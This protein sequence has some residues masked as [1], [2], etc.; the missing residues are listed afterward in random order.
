[1]NNFPLNILKRVYIVEN[2][3]AQTIKLLPSNTAFTLAEVLITLLIIGVVASLTIPALINNTQDQELK[4][5][6]KKS[7]SELTQATNLILLDNAG[8]LKGLCADNNDN[9]MRNLYAPYL[10]YT[11]SCNENSSWGNCWHNGLSEFWYMDGTAIPSGWTNAAG[12]ILNNGAFVRF[13][14]ISSQCNN[15][16]IGISR[17]GSI[18][19][20]V[21]GFK[22]PNRVGKDIFGT[23]IQYN[24]IKPRGISGDT[25]P[26]CEGSTGVN[27]GFGCPAVYLSQ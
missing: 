16:S 17:C 27:S 26:Y 22:K 21:N 2:S 24:G 3:S 7:Y 12:L 10:S 11:K 4:T 1:M 20:D 25:A 15:V 14:W 13:I 23:I 19:V 9:C 18:Y 8:S 6:W 5:A